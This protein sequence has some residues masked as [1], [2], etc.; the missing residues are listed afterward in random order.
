VRFRDILVWLC[1]ISSFYVAQ[2]PSAD[3]S[4]SLWSADALREKFTPV[5]DPLAA[6]VIQRDR[7][8]VIFLGDDRVVVY[9]VDS[10]GKLSSRTNPD[11]S[12]SFLLHASVY[13]A[14]VGH[15]LLTKDWP[16]HAHYSS[17]QVTAGGLLVRTGEKLTLLSQDFRQ[18]NQIT[19]PDLDRCI[20]SISGTQRTIL[21]N[22]LSNKLKI[23]RFD[24]FD[25]NNLQLKYSWSESPPLY[26]GYTVTDSGII[27]SDVS[28]PALI[29][30]KFASRKWDAIVKSTGTCSL[31]TIVADNWVFKECRDLTLKKRSNLV[32]SSMDGQILMTDQ[33][34]KGENLLDGPKI[35]KNEQF[36][37]FS[38]GTTAVKSRI[39]SESSEVRVATHVAVYDLR[40]KKRVQ[41]VNISPLPKNDYDF[42]LSPD[43]SKLAVL[44][45]QQVSVYSVFKQ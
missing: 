15:F 10:T 41:T 39:L 43:G 36:A 7:P 25:G 12:S 4:T 38:L 27:D 45:D 32:L 21:A 16:T 1:T 33:F 34:D 17:I 9:E 30:S 18:I 24:V 22:C 5:R 28:K 37:A 6:M 44:N 19:L 11:V 42:A 23:S 3:V 14:D 26:R 31:L 20:I 2:A 8:G 13:S 35:S 40:L 29:F